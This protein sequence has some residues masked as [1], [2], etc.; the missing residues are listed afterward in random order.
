L[1]AL[2]W[3][4][5]TIAIYALARLLQARLSGHALANTVIT[6]AGAILALESLTRTSD[7]AYQAGGKF[8]LWILGPATVALAIPLHEALPT[9]KRS[10]LPIAAALAAGSLT[11]VLS[12][13]GIARLLG[14]HPET[15]RSLAPKSVTTPIAMALA[16]SIG[17][18]PSLAAVFVILTGAVGALSG[19]GFLQRLGF[20]D[21]RAQG[22]ALGV[23]AHGMGTARAF[24]LGA[25]CG[26]FSTLG[27]TLNGV[28]TAL[29]LPWVARFF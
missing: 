22:F 27:M 9:L 21:P 16:Q 26:V 24:Q 18:L 13:V 10:L 29:V 15:L 4:A 11:A 7:D 17:G 8:L 19:A 28:V 25:E 20:R 14:A 2:L 23:A 3:I 5:I 12:A 1:I 6:S